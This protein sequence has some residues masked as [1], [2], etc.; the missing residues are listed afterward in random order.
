MNKIPLIFSSIIII[1]LIITACSKTELIPDD[2]FNPPMDQLTKLEASAQRSGDAEKGKKYL[3]EGDYVDSGIPLSI[4]KVVLGSMVDDYLQRDGIN[5][6][7]GHEYNAF[8][9]STGVELVSPN[10]LQCHSSVFDGELVIGL[11]NSSGNFTM[12]QSMFAGVLDAVVT[13]QYPVGTPEHTA[14]LPFS[15]S[16]KAI[17]SKIVT[18]TVGSNPADKIAAVLASHRNKDDLS[19]NEEEMLDIPDEVI[20]TDVPPWWLL[21]KKNAMFYTA[22]GRGDYARISMASSMLTVVDSTKAREVDESFVDVIA[23]IN[24]LEAPPYPKQIDQEMADIG[25][26]LF[27]D[28]CSTCHGTYGDL[29]TYPNLLVD[30]D[31]IQTDS[32]LVYANFGLGRFVDWYNTSWFGKGTNKAMLVP[33]RGYVAPPLD[34]IWAS[35][36]YFHNG[37]VPTLEKV[38]NSSTRPD[39]WSKEKTTDQYYNYSEVGIDYEVVDEKTSIYHYDTKLMGHDNSGHYFGDNLTT[40]E[41]KSIIEYL[42]TL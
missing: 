35:A 5:E 18:K 19:W 14:F 11:G 10:C 13:S 21:K 3:I 12:D 16:I 22:V 38:L 29:E 8:T 6:G 41:R 40:D 30:L 20:P 24:Q 39:I 36:P 25:A 28:N 7:I 32:M 9:T 33:E 1:I 34:G 37:S 23:Y 31:L 2:M 4:Y 15:K 17:G 42:K 26:E 27:L